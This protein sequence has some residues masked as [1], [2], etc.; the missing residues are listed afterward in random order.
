MPEQGG[1]GG[2]NIL[3]QKS[4]HVYN[5]DN[6]EKVGRDEAKQREEDAQAEAKHAQAEREYR[7]QALL[8]R[9]RQRTGALPASADSPLQVLPPAPNQLSVQDSVLASTNLTEATTTSTPSASTG[10]VSQPTAHAPK[11]PSAQQALAIQA[12]P[13]ADELRLMQLLGMPSSALAAPRRQD[14]AHAL[15]KEVDTM[16][17]AEHP[18]NAVS[19]H[20][21]SKAWRLHRCRALPAWCTHAFALWCTQTADL[22]GVRKLTVLM[23]ASH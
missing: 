14:G 22:S 2:L 11:Q 4:W 19:G 20:A 12:P 7:H 8:L 10:L 13:D 16:H 6:R 17:K 23:V 18:D 9:A 3:P 21:L 1:H 15:W 5:Q